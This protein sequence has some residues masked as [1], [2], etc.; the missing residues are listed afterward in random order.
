MAP[1][2]CGDPHT[3][4]TLQGV[5]RGG[6]EKSTRNTS[7]P[8]GRISAVGRTFTVEI[9]SESNPLYLEMLSAWLEYSLH[10]KMQIKREVWT[11]QAWQRCR[12]SFLHYDPTP[13]PELPLFVFLGL[14]KQSWEPVRPGPNEAMAENKH[15]ASRILVFY[16]EARVSHSLWRAQSKHTIS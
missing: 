14:S 13:N 9:G 16:K 8:D 7:H 5:E 15:F 12:C 4:E 1:L 2:P 11:L 10:R 3:W 6:V